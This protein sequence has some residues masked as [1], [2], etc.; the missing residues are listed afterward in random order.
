MW[1][2]QWFQN[3]HNK[4]PFRSPQ[5]V[6]YFKQGVSMDVYVSSVPLNGL[7]FG[8]NKNN[9]YQKVICEKQWAM[10]CPETN[11]LK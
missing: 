7:S 9:M 8:N 4:F 3:C 1:S 5:P 6:D 10:Q 11:Q 2:F